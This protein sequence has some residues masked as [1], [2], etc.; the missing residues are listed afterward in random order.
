[1]T[2]HVPC[3]PYFTLPSGLLT[4]A[5]P[6]FKPSPRAAGAETWSVPALCEAYSW[7]KNATGTGVIAIV[8]LGGGWRPADMTKYFASIGQPEPK[9]TDVSVDG[10][11]NV[12]GQ[13]DAD[14][15]CA[16]DI[17]VAGASFFCATGRPAEIRVYWSQD[18]QTAVTKAA[19]DGCSVMSCSWG[20]DEAQWTPAGCAEMQAAAVKANAAGMATFAA[21]GDNDSSDGGP[22]R[23]NVDCPASCP[24]VVGCGG[25]SKPK[26]GEEVVW[27]NNPG[28]TDGEGT[29][30][31]YSRDFKPMPAWQRDAVP[32]PPPP[33]ATRG[34]LV[35][36]VAANADPNYGYEIIV[37]GKSM[38]VGGT[39]AVAPLY[40]G[41]FAALSKPDDMLG[42]IGPDLWGHPECF[43]LI[44]RGGN[45]AYDAGPEPSPCTGLG[46]P[47][48]TAIAAM[49]NGV[50]D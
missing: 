28:Q 29:G 6:A 37:D 42:D 3:R 16:L 47:I 27:N 43:K 33:P 35:P 39:S 21:S 32:Q 2:I 41:L 7:P 45:G 13:S 44:T 14:V 10:T 8:E 23:A 50:G 30:G 38:V 26:S 15:E 36:D 4:D 18:I 22:N 20:A 48:G 19:E 34:R 17:Q 9:I 1:M 49:I 11:K 12:P 25:S 40:A 24:A 46:V 5:D 31:G